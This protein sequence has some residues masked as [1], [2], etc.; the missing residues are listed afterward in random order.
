MS[1]AAHNPDDY[2]LWK[3]I[4]FFAACPIIVLG[5]VNAFGMGEEH[6][7]PEFIEYDYLRIRTKVQYT[8]SK[9]QFIYKEATV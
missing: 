5:H 9:D 8:V 1:G 4:F 6:A 3:K 7:R 2:K